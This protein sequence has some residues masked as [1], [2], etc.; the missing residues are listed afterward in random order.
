[1]N[2][3]M[4]DYIPRYLDL[5]NVNPHTAEYKHLV[6]R[7]I[8]T[9]TF[10]Y[11]FVPI[12]TCDCISI[13]PVVGIVEPLSN[14]TISFKFKPDHYGTFIAEYEF[15]L[16]EFDF[17]PVI[18][19]VSGTC[20]VYDTGKTMLK[21]L[22]KFKGDPRVALDSDSKTLQKTIVENTEE[23]IM[24]PVNEPI[25]L[26]RSNMSNR[27]SID[28]SVNDQQ[29][30]SSPNNAEERAFSNN[31]SIAMS[32]KTMTAMT[33][34][35]TSAL[36]KKFKGFPSNREKE[37]LNYYN[38]TEKL[39]KDKDIKYIR[40][41]GKE[42][43]TDYEVSDVLSTR[44]D[45]TEGANLMKRRIDTSRYKTETQDSCVVDTNNE[46]LLKPTFNH[47]LNEKFFKTRHY[48]KIFLKM[49]TKV[50][51]QTRAEQRLGKLQTML[52]SNNIKNPVDFA[53]LM[54][55]DWQG[56]FT[57]EV[58]GEESNV[59][60]QFIKPQEVYRSHLYNSNEINLNS[61]KQDITHETNINLEEFNMYDILQRND[62]E[63]LGYKGKLFT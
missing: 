14:K 35:P 1:M 41:I 5:G 54:Q 9:A 26:S 36:S 4:K 6:L 15:R 19:S 10:E 40:F 13:D 31:N 43:M 42:L 21:S 33:S 62:I 12:T 22:K 51:I 44:K 23:E 60:I 16:S 55:K 30:A 59:K 32:K 3:H 17:K 37:F 20:N 50:L 63:A 46:Y 58:R 28:A 49:L 7:N 38:D 29:Q 52:K 18:I 61:L 39:I 47:N 45:G 8:I 56:F 48:Y 57:K 25:A 34:K 11:E 27:V 24:E 53:K 2:I